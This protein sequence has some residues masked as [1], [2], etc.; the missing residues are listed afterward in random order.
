M[1]NPTSRLILFVTFLTLSVFILSAHSEDSNQNSKEKIIHTPESVNEVL[2]KAVSDPGDGE[3]RQDED[4]EDYFIH[5]EYDKD[6]ALG[7]TAIINVSAYHEAGIIRLQIYGVNFPG[8]EEHLFFN[9]N[10]YSK[11]CG[12][13]WAI[14]SPSYEEDRF[15]KIVLVK[16]IPS[17]P[18]ISVISRHTFDFICA[19][20]YCSPDPEMRGFIDWMRDK[21]YEECITSRYLEWSMNNIER[22]VMKAFLKNRGNGL[23]QNQTV[24]FY[25]IVPT[26][27]EATYMSLGTGEGKECQANSYFPGFCPEPV[28]ADHLFLET[29]FKRTFGVN[30]KFVY[31]RMEIDYSDELGEPQLITPPNGNP[32]YRFGSRKQFLED[33]DFEEYSIIHWAVQSWNDRYLGDM[34][35]ATM[36]LKLAEVSY[37]P[38]NLLGATTYTHEWGHVLGFPH[39][40]HPILSQRRSYQW[41][42]VQFDG[43]M[44]NTY[45]TNPRGFTPGLLDPLDPMERYG[46]E[47][48]DGYLDDER[49]AAAYNTPI[50]EHHIR[51]CA[52]VDPAI[53]SAEIIGQDSESI[54]FG[55]ALGNLG[56]IP[57]GYIELSAFNGEQGAPIETRVIKRLAAEENMDHVFTIPRSSITSMEAI[58]V[59]DSNDKIEEMDEENNQVTIQISS[60]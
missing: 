19:D 47:P 30:I 52:M 54:T 1:F 57:V 50:I 26:D 8:S 5:V 38:F 7:E 34:T 55:L 20:E 42:A 25:D 28:P 18:K 53:V 43:I 45:G 23:E 32:Y 29:H 17:R 56:E 3:M 35:G 24:N 59:I 21:G 40:W 41:D 51:D 36:E 49:F 9:H 15:F 39:P 22:S 60:P 37:E 33:N 27:T 46:L 4:G 58:F 48:I 6:A 13:S 44:G 12:T 2:P 31:H 11:Y 16:P 14:R 10:C